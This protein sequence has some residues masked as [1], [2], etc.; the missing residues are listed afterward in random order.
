MAKLFLT[1]DLKIVKMVE[2]SLG[3]E[4]KEVETALAPHS[5]WWINSTDLKKKLFC[6]Q[7]WLNSNHSQQK[8]TKSI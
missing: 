4:I 7:K 3:T 2:K 5:L 1:L 6:A 8:C